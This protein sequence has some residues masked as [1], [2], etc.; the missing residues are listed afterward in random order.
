MD[1]KGPDRI[2]PTTTITVR[3]DLGGRRSKQVSA[4]RDSQDRSIYS[5][6]QGKKEKQRRLRQKVNVND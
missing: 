1:P 4:Y 5:V 3:D 6:H 2:N